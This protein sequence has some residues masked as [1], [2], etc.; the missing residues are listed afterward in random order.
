MDQGNDTEDRRMGPPVVAVLGHYGNRNLGDEAIVAATLGG[1]RRCLPGG[2]FFAVSLDPRDSAHRHGVA[3]FPLRRGARSGAVWRAPAAP[4]HGRPA[5]SARDAGSAVSSCGLPRSPLGRFVRYASRPLRWGV[6]SL[7]SL[8]LEIRFLVR[9]AAFVRHVDLVVIAGS[10]QFLDNFGGAGGFPYT[11]LKWTALARIARTPVTVTSVGAGPLTGR[12]SRLM[13]RAVLRMAARVSYRDA[14][15]RTLIEGERAVPVGDVRPDLA[16]ALG[17][18]NAARSDGVARVGVN[19]MPVYDER[20]WPDG[21]PERYARYVDAMAEVVAGLLE[22]RL[23]VFFYAT[24]PSDALVIEDVQQALA[25]SRYPRLEAETPATVDELMGV[26]ARADLLIATRFHGTVLAL[27][28]GRPVVSV[29]YHRKTADV[30]ASAGLDAYALALDGL[31]ADEVL[32]RVD[33]LRRR[34]PDIYGQIDA[35]VSNRRH[36]LEQ[37]FADLALIARL[38][39]SHSAALRAGTG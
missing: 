8:W 28:A 11:L 38:G 23:E 18:G 21:R 1:L 2:S 16:F 27:I 14:P 19:V 30:M 36:L 12:I 13:I 34:I 3:A 20:Y 39:P 33:G 24:Q 5:M 29:C 17:A 6:R 9:V 25:G 32:T 10:N 26:I 31:S 22:R 4:G 37:Q 35:V 15:S 7:R